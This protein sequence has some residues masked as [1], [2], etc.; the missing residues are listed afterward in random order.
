M[1]IKYSCHISKIMSISLCYKNIF[2]VLLLPFVNEIIY[3][4]C[5]LAKFEGGLR[6]LDSKC[7]LLSCYKMKLH[8]LGQVN[9][10]EEKI[11]VYKWHK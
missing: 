8:Y 11:F 7:R 9:D 4:L 3:E 6:I 5:I 2:A 1:C 10:K